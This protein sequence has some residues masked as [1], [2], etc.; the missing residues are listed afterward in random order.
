MQLISGKGASMGGYGSGRRGNRPVAE[1][2][3]ALPIRR[4]RRDIAALVEHTKR[5]SAV[6]TQDRLV[7]T[8]GA[9]Y[10]VASIG[11]QLYYHGW[12]GVLVL[13]L[14]YS[15]HQEPVCD[16][17]SIEATP[18]N[19]GGLRYWFWCPCGRRVGVVY[20]PG[21]YWRCRHCYNITYQSSN[22]SDP[23]VSR[24]LRDPAAFF[25]LARRDNSDPIGAYKRTTAE[26]GVLLK[27]Y[28]KLGRR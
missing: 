16:A 20:S 21:K 3:L 7:W 18:C 12:P 28:G 13:H 23:R 24:L 27:A 14:Q 11:Y 10:E 26:L 8:S 19:F 25:A 15:Y 6:Y 22:D 9:R 4:F 1:Q 5:G 17:I 2:S